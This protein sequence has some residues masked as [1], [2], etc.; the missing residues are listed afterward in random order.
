MHLSGVEP[1]GLWDPNPAPPAAGKETHLVP[2][3]PQMLLIDPRMH[4]YTQVILPSFKMIRYKNIHVR[5]PS[6][7]RASMRQAHGAAQGSR[8][9]TTATQE[10]AGDRQRIMARVA[11]DSNPFTQQRGKLDRVLPLQP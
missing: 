6:P 1:V 4:M 9:A 11:A 10:R 3:A 7:R 5:V 8:D 2:V